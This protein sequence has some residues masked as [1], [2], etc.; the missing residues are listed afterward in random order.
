MEWSH[1]LHMVMDDLR[2]AAEKSFT[3]HPVG[4]ETV[5]KEKTLKG[6][7]YTPDKTDIHNKKRKKDPGGI[8]KEAREPEAIQQHCRQHCRADAYGNQKEER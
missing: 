5:L 3:P 4:E 7:G 8:G 1:H 2:Y 6:T